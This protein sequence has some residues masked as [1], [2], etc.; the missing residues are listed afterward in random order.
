MAKYRSWGQDQGI[1]LVGID[2][3]GKIRIAV[4]QRREEGAERMRSGLRIIH[5]D[6]IRGHIRVIAYQGR[7]LGIF[8]L[9]NGGTSGL[10]G[11]KVKKRGERLF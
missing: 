2:L 10:P 7:E 5:G 9:R 6:G 8:W 3:E 11:T 1:R 4:V